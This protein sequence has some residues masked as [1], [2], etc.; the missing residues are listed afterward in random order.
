MDTSPLSWD[1]RVDNLPWVLF[2]GQVQ[3]QTNLL[4]LL[5][6]AEYCSSV[7][8][9]STVEESF[10]IFDY[11]TSYS[12]LHNFE[13]VYTNQ[14]TIS[15]TCQPNTLDLDKRTLNWQVPFE[16]LPNYWL[17]PGSLDYSLNVF[18]EM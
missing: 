17:L 14:D 1:I 9:T 4:E 8:T 15:G 12:E 10:D 3:S 6:G 16:P 7:S 18:S 13:A 11:S 5:Y 2:N